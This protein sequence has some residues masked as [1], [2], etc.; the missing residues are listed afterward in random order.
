M[1]KFIAVLQHGVMNWQTVLTG[2]FIMACAIIFFIGVFKKAVFNKVANKSLRK[3][4]LSSMSLILAFPATA[5]YFVIEGIAFEYFWYAYAGVSMLTVITY[6]LYENYLFRDLIDFIGKKTVGEWFN[7]L[8]TSFV[9]RKSN[10]ETKAE[11]IKVNA[12]LQETVREEVRNELQTT[13]Q[14][15]ED[16]NDL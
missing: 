8:K 2:G 9:N 4:I 6:W 14:S 5:L 15:D 3:L 7:V 13:T 10:K 11:L 1:D 16:L 12:G